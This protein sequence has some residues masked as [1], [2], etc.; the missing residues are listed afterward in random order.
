MKIFLV[1]LFPQTEVV[2]YINGI[3]LVA[4]GEV[5]QYVSYIYI[6]IERE[7]YIY[8]YIYGFTSNSSAQT[9]TLII[10]RLWSVHVYQ[11]HSEYNFTGCLKIKCKLCPWSIQRRNE[12]H[13]RLLKYFAVFYY[14]R[15]CPLSWNPNPSGTMNDASLQMITQRLLYQLA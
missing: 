5:G 11:D 4:H 12:N 15:G 1:I 3:G 9:V 2:T 13:I 8:I 7:R 14:I 10:E 6:Y